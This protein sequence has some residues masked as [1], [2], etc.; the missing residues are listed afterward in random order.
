MTPPASAAIRP[1]QQPDVHALLQIIRGTRLE[2]GLERRVPQLL[3][4]SDYALLDVYHRRRS[5]YFVATNAGEV[6]GG[7]G[8]APLPESDGMTCELQRM[9]LLPQHRGK[10][11]GQRLLD[12]CIDAARSFGYARCYAETISE[13]TTAIAFYERNGFRRLPGPKGNS[14]HPHNDCWLE[15]DLTDPYAAGRYGF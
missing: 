14:G 12:A 3:E 13:M 6:V 1:L 15:L 11:I 8:I 5:A 9:Y 2:Y 10:G 7:A 4:P